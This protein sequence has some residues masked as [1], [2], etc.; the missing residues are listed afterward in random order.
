V[1]SRRRNIGN[2]SVNATSVLT[3]RLFGTNITTAED[4]KPFKAAESDS[5]AAN[6][7]YESYLQAVADLQGYKQ[8]QVSAKNERMYEAWQRAEQSAANSRKKNAGVAV[9]KTVVKETNRED[10]A[11]ANHERALQARAQHLLAQAADQGHSQA[12]VQLGNEELEKTHAAYIAAD[13]G[14]AK[15]HLERAMGLYRRSKTA[16]GN[17]NLGSLLWNGYP[18][19]QADGRKADIILLESDKDAS[20]TAFNE[21]ID[22]GDADAMLFVGVAQLGIVDKSEEDIVIVDE[23]TQTALVRGLKLIE[24]AASQG[25]GGALYYL[26]LFYLNGHTGLGVAPCE[27]AEF[28]QRL[29]AAA[30]SFH[31]EALFLRGHCFY[32]GDH[33][34]PED[35]RK[36]TDD[37]LLAA[38]R[39]SADAAVSAGAILH[40]GHLPIIPR[41]QERA[42]ALY[43]H[44]GEL[45]SIEGWRNVVACYA[46][47][48]GVAQNTHVAKYIAETMLKDVKGDGQGKQP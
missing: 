45:G 13:M 23:T 29:D 25:H 35:V 2:T 20:M 27:P 21:A 3:M 5:E 47:G 31:A 11:Q 1:F 38:D 48:E 34:Y 30:D 26:A 41:N 39:G 42:F 16:E 6:R 12:I 7:T 24:Q 18:G 14:L 10:S 33:G 19:D 8:E 36:A 37:F 22:H 4:L 46:A 15:I 44:A 17:Y 9:V 32:N 43:Q 40:K 28:V